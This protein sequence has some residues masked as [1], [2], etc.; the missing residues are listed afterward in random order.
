VCISGGFI[1]RAATAV[2]LGRLLKRGGMVALA[3]QFGSCLM[4]GGRSRM[5]FGGLRVTYD[6]HGGSS[7]CLTLQSDNAEA[8]E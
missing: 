2:G 8:A 4:S 6:R 5:I 3:V 1:G 7:G